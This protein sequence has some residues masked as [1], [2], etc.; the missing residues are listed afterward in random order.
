MEKFYITTSLPY[1]NAPPHIGFALEAVQADVN[2]RWRRI[3]GDDVFFLSGTD[4]HGAKIVRSAEKAG[5]EPKEFV[6]GNVAY[7][8]KLLAELSISNDDFIRTSDE[9]RHW[10]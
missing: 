7:V 1:V 6:E 5:K 9:H 4:E 8:K 10:T 3:K 2:A